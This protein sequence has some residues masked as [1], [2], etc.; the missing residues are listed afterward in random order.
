M[1]IIRKSYR[2]KI[3]PEIEIIRFN[4][5]LILNY[6]KK[7][8]IYWNTKKWMPLVFFLFRNWNTRQILTLA[9]LA[10]IIEPLIINNDQSNMPFQWMRLRYDSIVKVFFCQYGY[11]CQRAVWVMLT[12]APVTNKYCSLSTKL[13]FAY[14]R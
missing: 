7:G 12:R 14:L 9:R 1:L 2:F 4:I 13:L 8:N 10:D 3:S 11:S 6:Y 5:I